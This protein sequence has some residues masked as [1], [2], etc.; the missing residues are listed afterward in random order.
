[1]PKLD[2]A[3]L[4]RPEVDWASLERGPGLGE[5]FLGAV[6]GGYNI[7]QGLRKIR[8]TYRG[9]EPAAKTAE[10]VT[11]WL[12]YD[13]GEVARTMGVEAPAPIPLRAKIGRQ[14][15]MGYETV[16]EPFQR[17]FEYPEAA[18]IESK[19]QKKEP[20]G[21]ALRK[22]LQAS[23]HPGERMSRPYYVRNF[24]NYYEILN[25]KYGMPAGYRHPQDRKWAIAG[26][27]SARFLAPDVL[28]GSIKVLRKA[29]PLARK[30]AKKTGS[31]TENFINVMHEDH[32]RGIA[33]KRLLADTIRTLGKKNGT[34]A[35]KLYKQWESEIATGVSP[36]YA[37][38]RIMPGVERPVIPRP[39]RPAMVTP[40]PP[41]EIP[42]PV[43]IPKPIPKVVKPAVSAK[44]YIG[45]RPGTEQWM[46]VWQRFPELQGE[47]VQYS[48]PAEVAKEE[49]I[50][51]YAKMAKKRIEEFKAEKPVEAP[52]KALIVA[53]KFNTE[54]IASAKKIMRPGESLEENIARTKDW[55]SSVLTNDMVSSNPELVNFFQKEGGFSKE[56]AEFIVSKRK[57]VQVIPR[58]VRKEMKEPTPKPAEV[59]LIQEAKKYKTA[60]EFVSGLARGEI[61]NY[62]DIVPTKALNILNK[63]FA[64]YSTAEIPEKFYDK[65]TLGELITGFEKLGLG[66][67][68]IKESAIA[69]KKAGY[70]K[71]GNIVLTDEGAIPEQQLTDIWNK[72]QAKPPEVPEEVSAI[73]FQATLVPGAEWK[74]Q[75]GW[76]KHGK[77]IY[78]TVTTEKAQKE[79][80]KSLKQQGIETTVTET[81]EG[82]ISIRTAQEARLDQ[83]YE[84]GKQRQKPPAIG[85]SLEQVSTI[86]GKK[87]T[88]Q[89]WQGAQGS[90][91]RLINNF[92]FYRDAP[93]AFRNAIRTQLI[94]GLNNLKKEVYDK[95]AI[96]LW[97]GLKPKEVEQSVELIYARNQ[98]SRVRAGKGDPRLSIEQAD[99]LVARLT[100]EVTNPEVIAAADRWRVVANDTFEDLVR[101]GKLSPESKIEDYAPIYVVDYT[102]PWHFNT[103]IPTRLKRPYR[104]YVKKAVGTTKESRQDAEALLGH[105]LRVRHDNLIEDFIRT[106]GEKYDYRNQ[107][108]H[109]QRVEMFGSY[110]A[111]GKYE[112]PKYPKSGKVYNI[113]GKSYRGYNPN[114]PFIR[115]VFPLE[116]EDKVYQALGK[117]S[118]AYLLPENVYKTF[119]RFSEKG[120]PLAPLVY[121]INQATGIWKS[122][123]ILG[124]FTGFNFNNLIG[125]T[126]MMAVQ[127]PH[128]HKVLNNVEP[129]VRFLSTPATKYTPEQARLNAFLVDNAILDSAFI[130]TELPQ[131]KRA[132]NPVTYLIQKAQQVSEFREE[133]MRTAQASY[134]LQEM[135]VG[136]AEAIRQHYSW[137]NTDE[138]TM[139]EA[140]GK[141]AR[142]TMIDYNAMSK[143]FRRLIRGFVFPFGCVDEKT[144][145][146]TKDGW[147]RYNEAKAGNEIW[148]YDIKT[149]QCKWTKIQGIFK[150]Y[151]DND[152]DMIEIKNR[153]LNALL[154]LNHSC[155]VILNGSRKTIQAQE[156]ETINIS[157]QLP[158]IANPKDNVEYGISDNWLKL[159]GWYIT[160]GT[161]FKKYNYVVI[162]QSKP[163]YVKE[164]RR[165]LTTLN[166]D[167][168]ETIVNPKVSFGDLPKHRFYLK[169]EGSEKLNKIYPEKKII[170]DFIWKLSPRQQSI[171][172]EALL[173]GDGSKRKE[174]GKWRIF[175]TAKEEQ[176]DNFQMLCSLN[177]IA[178]RKVKKGVEIQTRNTRAIRHNGK[179]LIKRTS[180]RGTIWCP[181]TGT[182]YWLA[183]RNGCIFLTGNT[184]YF[185]GSNLMTRF[186]KY[187]PL[188]A[189]WKFLWIPIVATAWNMLDKNKREMEEQLP[190][191]VRHRVHFILGKTPEGNI[192]VW[193]LQLPQDVLIGTK[194]Y[195][196]AVN[197]ATRVMT[198]EK[199]VEQA[200]K[201]AIK[202]AGIKE[203]KGIAY[204]TTPY[205]RFIRG[206]IL[207]RDPYDMSPIYPTDVRRM[208][209]MRVAYHQG[210][211]MTKC[212]I[213]F[214]SMYIRD[215]AMRGKDAPSAMKDVLKNIGS[216]ESLGIYDVTPNTEIILPNGVK[217]DYDSWLKSRDKGLREEGIFLDI[218]DGFIRSGLQPNE[219]Y[220]SPAFQKQLGK[221]R[222]FYADRWSPELGV[223]LSG[224]M[225]QRIENNPK[226]IQLWAQNNYE[227]AKTQQEKIYWSRMLE[228]IRKGR[229]FERRKRLKKG[230]R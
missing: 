9:E 213:P 174:N 128:P 170:K 159:I 136:R 209:A 198:G 140:L 57:Q 154:T 3:T 78:K 40:A 56:V 106:Q 47:M 37:L 126:W 45:L 148:S 184:W 36:D 219:Y 90:W 16:I 54:I 220:Q 41:A 38:R 17:V 212:M 46:E 142:D 158:I 197:E 65:I 177:G 6:A 64:N 164:I 74:T 1:M 111:F 26:G 211:F 61:V 182:G 143:T 125:D 69:L 59:S 146:L 52:P 157:T 8:E 10:L 83:M 31:A 229:L 110:I 95:T 138:L 194:I 222:T 80:L 22:T 127:S 173:R 101:R 192:K 135:N 81:P 155:P 123:A 121:L 119:L 215:Y 203:A 27:I 172:I 221:L 103:T 206:L 77:P 32:L 94:G 39:E 166:I 21:K 48:K 153:S 102:P 5:R 13:L 44:P 185:K 189:V 100:G 25:K 137:I 171:L 175:V 156:L 4:E 72:T 87:Q 161:K 218:V 109:A 129:A 165:I 204:L 230:V 112:T 84:A 180:Y 58:G 188:D 29:T 18:F 216:T 193:S 200:A 152:E 224:R 99:A 133:I 227:R 53:D 195:S 205:I 214:M 139:D 187:K 107:M 98:A 178:T 63:T 179:R 150:H 68:I 186:H 55:I 144:E 33:D 86:E 20:I 116:V 191:Y 2:W 210:L 228:N 91:T 19:F 160:E 163:Q 115:Q 168:S 176:K 11:K 225:K 73:P 66:E 108:T 145:C 207:Q 49:A 134:F 88:G 96:A 147:K 51:K 196:I 104:G 114:M 7:P 181:K 28:F 43:E 105:L 93:P 67:E 124:R 76:N 162:Y 15:L 117:Y 169:K 130:A 190:D 75:T 226:V 35:F 70:K 85:L 208:D 92:Y 97:G 42:K 183:R 71:I 113:E 149:N 223:Y 202:A 151:F 82:K 60:E 79:I 118:K 12:G 14:A 131:I 89:Q 217:Y 34:K 120:G 141:I 201:D 167:Y 199:T 132:K 30:L 23:L 62:D 50:Q 24:E 122:M